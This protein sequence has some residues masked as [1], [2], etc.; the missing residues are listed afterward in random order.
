MVSEATFYRKNPERACRRRV[1]RRSP[2]GCPVGV[3]PTAPA[4]PAPRD[5]RSE[6]QNFGSEGNYRRVLYFLAGIKRLAPSSFGLRG[7]ISFDLVG[8]W[9]SLVEHLVRD[10][11]AH[12]DKGL[13]GLSAFSPNPEQ[14]G[15]RKRYVFH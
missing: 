13:K 11:D 9:L 1:E 2:A 3:P 14:L 4:V 8:A 10:Q 12:R 6:H 5:L 7:S 15:R